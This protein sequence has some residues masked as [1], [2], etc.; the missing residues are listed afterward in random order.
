MWLHKPHVHKTGSGS[1]LN[2]HSNRK[3]VALNFLD[4]ISIVSRLYYICSKYILYLECLEFVNM[5]YI[6]NVHVY[7]YEYI[8]VCVY[9]QHIVMIHSCQL[10]WL[11]FI[12]LHWLHC[13]NKLICHNV[14]KRFPIE[15]HLIWVVSNFF[16]L[17]ISVRNNAF[18][19]T[20]APVFQCVFLE[21]P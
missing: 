15:G 9:L 13:T 18:R 2:H 20:F 6:C 1:S 5:P 19:N 16:C 8:C 21:V 3:F 14:F 7:V 12:Y 11:S 4:M 17:F 10:M